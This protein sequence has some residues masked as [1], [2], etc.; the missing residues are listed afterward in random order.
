[1]PT[2]GPEGVDQVPYLVQEQ[3]FQVEATQCDLR[4]LEG[5]APRDVDNLWLPRLVEPQD[6]RRD[7]LSSDIQ[8]P[9]PRPRVQDHRGDAAS[10]HEL[11]KG[12]VTA[13]EISLPDAAE[14]DMRQSS[15]VTRW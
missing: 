2:A 6:R 10:A 7:R 1:V 8:L 15:R 5:A 3:V 11:R 9:I 12:D 14:P 4:E 13:L